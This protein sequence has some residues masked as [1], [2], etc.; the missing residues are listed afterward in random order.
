VF[1]RDAHPRYRP[2]IG[3]QHIDL[4]YRGIGRMVRHDPLRP[5]NRQITRTANENSLRRRHRGVSRFP[6]YD[7]GIGLR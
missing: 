2:D 3:R 5:G 7:Y 4:R 6:A 1:D